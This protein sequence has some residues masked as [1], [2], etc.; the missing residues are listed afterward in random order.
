MDDRIDVVI[1]MGGVGSRFRK[2]GYTVPKYMIEAK[3]KTLF[4]WSMISLEGYK[5]NIDQYIFIAMKDEVC[6]VETFINGKCE[7]MRIK[8]YHVII[9]D[10][11]TDGQAT[12]AM[13]AQEYWNPEHA[14]LIYNI[15]TYV[16]AGEMNSEELRGDGF[17]PCF[18]AEG[19]HW[20]FVRLDEI[21]KVVEIK[22][23][24]RISNYCTLGAYYFKTCQIY[25]DLY[26]DYYSNTQELVNAEKYVAPLYDYLLSKGGEI[27]I[28]EIKPEM[29]HVL[30]TPEELRIFLNE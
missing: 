10:Y 21:G 19:D 17:I 13:M 1:T 27:Y 26:I 9:L 23:K 5:Q 7:E 29:V 6:D 25:K 4:E 24:K 30:G 11:L 22:E 2:M 16:E 8:N 28:S 14:L 3:G 15:D 20:S 12:T 18:K